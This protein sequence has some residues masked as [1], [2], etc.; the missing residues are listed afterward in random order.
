MAR[1]LYVSVNTV[2]THMR[3]IYSKLGAHD[4]SSAVQR[5]SELRLLSTR[6]RGSHIHRRTPS[7]SSPPEPL[8]FEPGASRS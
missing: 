5:A 8:I 4:R 3:N 7:V 1:A 6:L 2:N